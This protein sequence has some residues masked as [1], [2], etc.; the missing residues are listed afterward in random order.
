MSANKSPRSLKWRQKR[1]LFRVSAISILT[2]PI[3]TRQQEQH[4]T[5]QNKS[6]RM[7]IGAMGQAV[8]A[9][10]MKW[11]PPRATRCL[12]PALAT[13]FAGYILACTLIDSYPRYFVLMPV[14]LSL[15]HKS[16]AKI[17]KVPSSKSSMD[18]FP[19]FTLF[20][21]EDMEPA[22]HGRWLIMIANPN[23]VH[24]PSSSY[25]PP[26]LTGAGHQ[27]TIPTSMDH[28]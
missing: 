3:S 21:S 5:K 16:V 13:T 17:F 24:R 8:G 19:L 2:L 28:F 22:I 27:W 15:I 25:S 20:S 6:I 18:T 10:L 14:S 4:K 1:S 9:C 11:G 7:R 26:T 23:R 12:K